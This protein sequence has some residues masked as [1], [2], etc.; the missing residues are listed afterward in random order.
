MLG[1]RITSRASRIAALTAGAAVLLGTGVAVGGL[2]SEPV[3]RELLAESN[4]PRGAPDRT[5]ALSRVT[6]K[7]GAEL[8]LHHHEGT[9]VA[10][11]EQGTLTYTVETGEVRVRAGDPDA[12]TAELVQTIEAGETA[13]IRAGQW[14]VEQP[15]DIHQARN[16]GKR[17]IVIYLAT[18][19][20]KG[21]PPSTPN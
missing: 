7:P 21:A 18:L 16:A 9:Q 2:G 11:I 20:R 8:A 15:S 12:G 14:I 1:G 17:D 10:R 13:K 4:N 3:T 19:L 6:I 5:L